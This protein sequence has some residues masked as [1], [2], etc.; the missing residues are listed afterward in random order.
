[1][2]FAF[3]LLC[4]SDLGELKWDIFALCIIMVQGAI[5][6]MNPFRGK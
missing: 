3:L 6:S 2:W 1:M 4:V 5:Y